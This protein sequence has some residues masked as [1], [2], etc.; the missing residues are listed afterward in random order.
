MQE[1]IER[2]QVRAAEN[3]DERGP[4]GLVFYVDDKYIN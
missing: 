2:K 1:L 3:V 4:C